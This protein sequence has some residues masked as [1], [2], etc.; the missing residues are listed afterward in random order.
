MPSYSL[1]G[2]PLDHPAGCWRLKKGTQRRPLPGARAVKVSVPGRHGD[3]PVVG[4]DLEATTFGLTFKVTSATPSGA[5]GGY[6]Q[7]ERNLEALSALLGTRH[8]LMKLR[9]QAGNLVRV[10]DVTIN[11]AS[12]PEVNTGAATARITAVVEVP[13][14]LWRD[15]SESTW[16][17]APDQLAQAVTT[18]AGATGPIVDAL[19]RFTGPAVQLSIGDV[20]TGGWVLRPG[21]L[22]AG[23]R[24]LIDCGRMRAAVVTSD[25]WDLAAGDDVTG[26]ID[27]IGP[28]SQFR[29][30][31]LTSSVAVADPF[32]RAVLVS[33]SATSTDAPSK[34]E[35][36]ARRAY[37]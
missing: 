11:A 36:R 19:L 5:D 12:E 26:E 27:A 33:T 31:H 7:M 17:G 8:R 20:A 6:E 24:L 22:L 14:A 34:V 32:S 35:I 23:Q 15:D 9:Y 18:L 13:G 4:L 21:G 29:W 25:T 28:G 37:L 1:D 3:I 10:A 30:L 2:V 16:A